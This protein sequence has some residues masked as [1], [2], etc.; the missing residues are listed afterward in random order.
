MIKIGDTVT[1]KKH[2]VLKD[3]VR[4]IGKDFNGD[5]LYI[6]ENGTM[7]TKDELLNT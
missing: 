2:P 1:P 7:Y 5:P 3:K 6:L 4:K